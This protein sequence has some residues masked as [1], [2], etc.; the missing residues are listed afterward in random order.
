MRSFIVLAVLAGLCG[1]TPASAQ[2]D[3]REN[4]QERRIEQ[5]E[6]SGELTRGEAARLQGQ[7]RRIDGEVARDRAANG[8]VLTPGKRARVNR[9]ENQA[10]R[11]IYDKKHNDR[12]R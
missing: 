8:G 3:R 10:G 1:T 7:Q 5:G 4:N 12:V 2:V 9:Q 11:T 6:R